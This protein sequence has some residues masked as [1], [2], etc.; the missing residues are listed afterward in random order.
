M[1]NLGEG[2]FN[3]AVMPLPPG[4][5][6]GLMALAR[7]GGGSGD[8]RSIFGEGAIQ[9]HGWETDP[10]MVAAETV[11]LIDWTLTTRFDQ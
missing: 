11:G 1:A 2:A 7:G 8:Q 9:V 3:E 4:M 6:E 5:M 10:R